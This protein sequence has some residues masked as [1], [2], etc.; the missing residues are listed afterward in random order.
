MTSASVSLEGKNIWLVQSLPVSPWQ[1]LLAK[2]KLHLLLTIIPALILTACVELVIQPS[3]GMAL[4]L[5]LIVMAFILFMALLGLVVDL[6]S[7][8]LNWT[9][10]SAVVKQSMAVMIAIFGG[11]VV[12]LALGAGYLVLKGLLSPL[13]YAV[14]VTAALLLVSWS[15]IKWLRTKGV[16]IFRGL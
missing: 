11:W 2:L 10:E 1:V 16:D 13:L 5:P 3:L 14:L 9:N 7:P 8:N 6:K 12:V 4:L 15:M